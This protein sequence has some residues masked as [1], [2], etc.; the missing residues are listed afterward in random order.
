MTKAFTTV[1]RHQS[2]RK[3]HTR[4]KWSP[5][6]RAEWLELFHRSGQ[7]VREFSRA[8]DLP[9][10]TMSLWCQ[11]QA[12]AGEVAKVGSLVEIPVSALKAAAPSTGAAVGLR[13]CNGVRIKI[14][15]GTDLQWL[16]ALVQ[17]LTSA[18]A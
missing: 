14:V 16:G 7:T 9:P 12:K 10:A 5:A 3:S 4:L 6:E 15:A 17:V 18:S 2:A 8:N 13:L 1:T 11:K